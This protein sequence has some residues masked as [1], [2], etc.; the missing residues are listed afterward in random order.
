MSVGETQRAEVVKADVGGHTMQVEV[1]KSADR[2]Q[3]VK[4]GDV[5]S[6]EG[7]ANSVEAIATSISGVLQRV[8]P[9]RA[10][11]EFGVDVG[12]ESG[13]LTAMLVKGTG[14]AT[15]KITLEWEK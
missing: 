7:V 13:A 1:R 8:S 9:K 11:V 12:V 6:F 2:E 3:D 14:T 10:S 5:L 4:I 15:L